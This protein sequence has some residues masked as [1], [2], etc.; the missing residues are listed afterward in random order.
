M[1]HVHGSIV[2]Y[3]KYLQAVTVCNKQEASLKDLGSLLLS[4]NV[5]VRLVYGDLPYLL[6]FFVGI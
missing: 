5:V 3:L 6:C 2:V 1:V 4:C